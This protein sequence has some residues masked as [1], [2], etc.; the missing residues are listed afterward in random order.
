MVWKAAPR[1]RVIC[2]LCEAP[3]GLAAVQ[4]LPLGAIDASSRVPKLG[5]RET[6]RSA[7]SFPPPWEVAMAISSPSGPFSEATVECIHTRVTRLDLLTRT[8]SP[9]AVDVNVGSVA[10]A[11]VW[12]PPA[13]RV[14]PR[15][16]VHR[17]TAR[18]EPVLP[19]QP[20]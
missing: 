4:M 1:P 16:S 3:V 13:Q 9:A 2:S 20:T 14:A 19:I 18:P 15:G 12:T 8:Q 10:E 5:P 17:L 7:D 6:S 11:M